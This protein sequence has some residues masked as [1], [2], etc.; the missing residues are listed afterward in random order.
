MF[1]KTILFLY[2]KI[3]YDNEINGFFPLQ[4]VFKKAYGYNY[5]EQEVIIGRQKNNENIIEIVKTH[6]PDYVLLHAYQD[7]IYMSTL[8]EI[9]RLGSITLCWNSDDGWRHEYFKSI[10]DHVHHPITVSES[11]FEKYKNG[12]YKVIKSMWATNEDYYFK[13]LVDKCVIPISFIGQNYGDR[14]SLLKQ[15]ANGSN[16]N[17]ELFGKGFSSYI[18]LDDIVKIFNASKINLSFSSSSPP[19]QHIKQAKGRVFEVP[20]CGGFLLT[21]YF[22][23]LEKY[24]ENGKE[25]VWFKTIE[26]GIE[27]VNYYLSHEDK[28]REIAKLGY[29]R[30]QRDHTWVKRYEDI[31]RKVEEMHI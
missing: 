15:I 26:E 30:A 31:F 5:V 11:G 2:V 4:K 10:A 12:G 7:Q 14:L 25:I 1:D 28:R 22:P 29:E 13:I 23:H 17:I 3:N 18:P 20:M 6:K 27:K 19:N 8:D 9:N 21:E 16:T 24:Y